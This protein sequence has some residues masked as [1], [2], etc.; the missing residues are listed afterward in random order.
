MRSRLQHRCKWVTWS[1]MGLFTF[2]D[3]E[4]QRKSNVTIVT[5]IAIAV[6][7]RFLNYVISEM[8]HAVDSA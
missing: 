5:A 3:S 8:L 2:S 6:F 4:N 1:S 7:E